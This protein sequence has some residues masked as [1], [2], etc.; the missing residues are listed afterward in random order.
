MSWISVAELR[1][2]WGRPVS[3]DFQYTSLPMSWKYHKKTTVLTVFLPFPFLV[4][5][6]EKMVCTDQ[7]WHMYTTEKSEHPNV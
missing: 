5:A 7:K 1:V 3:S 6:K 2:P 4:L